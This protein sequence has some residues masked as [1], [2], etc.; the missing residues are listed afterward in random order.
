MTKILK[1]SKYDVVMAVLAT[2]NCGLYVYANIF[3]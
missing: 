1:I 3:L 2:F